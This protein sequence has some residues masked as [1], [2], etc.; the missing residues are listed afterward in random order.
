MRKRWISRVAWMLIMAMV[1]SC[2]PVDS[3][4]AAEVT[5]SVVEQESEQAEEPVVEQESEQAEEPITED[6]FKYL[7]INQP[8]QQ[9]G[10]ERLG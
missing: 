8:E 6:M 9:E 2:V 3:I 10:E 1:L 5:E 7:L 4:R